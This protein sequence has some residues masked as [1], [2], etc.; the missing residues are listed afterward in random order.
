MKVEEGHHLN[1]HGMQ[2][3]ENQPTK[4]GRESLP[5]VVAQEVTQDQGLDGKKFTV[6]GTFDE[7]DIDGETCLMCSLFKT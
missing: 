1:K 4:R 7:V 5:K 2:V 6:M 3:Y